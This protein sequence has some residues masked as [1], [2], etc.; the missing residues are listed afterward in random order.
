MSPSQLIILFTHQ[1]TG[2]SRPSRLIRL[3]RR[4]GQRINT[5]IEDALEKAF[6]GTAVLIS[7]DTPDMK[8]IEVD[9]PLLSSFEDFVGELGDLCVNLLTKLLRETTLRARMQSALTGRFDQPYSAVGQSFKIINLQ[10]HMSRAATSYRKPITLIFKVW[11][12]LISTT[13]MPD[14]L[15]TNS[16]S[17]FSASGLPRQPPVTP[18]WT[19]TL[20]AST[21]GS[22]FKLK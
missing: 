17:V 5:A 20:M 22:W 4:K 21:F 2:L 6:P 16:A 1:G 10:T 19:T 9:W 15:S 12:E 18:G 13:L 14:R 3:A 11:L 8:W 7:V